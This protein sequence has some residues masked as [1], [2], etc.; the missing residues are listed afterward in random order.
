VASVTLAS[1]HFAI[2]G[3]TC[4]AQLPAAATCTVS[5]T[6]SPKLAGALYAALEINGSALSVPLTGVGTFGALAATDLNVDGRSDM[7][8]HNSSTGQV[9]RILM[10]GL[11]LGGQAMVYAEPNLAWRIVGDA[12]FDGDRIADLLWRNTATG[13]VYQQRFGANGRPADGA[14]IHTEPNAA[15]KIV[16]TPDLDGDGRAD[17]LWWN[18]TTGQVYAM[19]MNGFGITSQGFVVTEPDTAWRIVAV[20]DFAAASKKNQLVWRHKTTGQ[21]RLMTVTASGGVFGQSS[22]LIYTEPAAA[23][24][25]LGA[26][27]LDGDRKSDLLWRNEATG[28]I[29]AM[30]MN[31]PA[32]A[33]EGTVYMEP[34]L[35]WKIV[36]QGDYNG[37]GKADLLWRN[38][39]TGQVYMV[40]MNGLAIA[41]Q[42]MVYTEPN[43]AWKVMGPWEYEQAN[44][45]LG[46]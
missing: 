41:A 16:H 29:Y 44:D 3:N 45:T 23:W 18:S 37:D 10:N 40:L 30:L 35:A 17:L 34:N 43:P 27:D 24:K 46:P 9:Y 7:L 11:I 14:F 39:S 22:A 20:G 5:V 15:W 42:G 4:P 25:I 31:G 19:L 13:Q 6:F 36:A 1:L 2:A 28:R 33:S 21:V 12:D 32:I 26:P 38:D 8:W